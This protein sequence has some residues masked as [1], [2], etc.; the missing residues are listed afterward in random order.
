MATKQEAIEYL[1][2]KYNVEQQ[3][4]SAYTMAWDYEGAKRSQIVF[5]EFFDTYILVSSPFA[6][7]GQ[8][9]ADQAFDSG[10]PWGVVKSGGFYCFSHAV[11]LA[12]LD[13]SE[14]DVP[15]SIMATFADG[16]EDTL[17]LGDNL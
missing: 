16:Y 4:D 1:K 3:T 13:S 6:K 17:G 11:L 15:L 14:L 9:S 2:S 5:I 7:V 12:D 8:I 10:L